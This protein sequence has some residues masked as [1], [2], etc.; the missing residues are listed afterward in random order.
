MKMMML[1]ACGHVPRLSN[2]DAVPYAV[3]DVSEKEGL[4]DA[5]IGRRRSL[6]DPLVEKQVGALFSSTH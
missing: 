4:L 1:Y 6:S 5:E 2:D 3:I